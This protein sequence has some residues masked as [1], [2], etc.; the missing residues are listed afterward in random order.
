MAD[1][2]LL[3]QRVIV[4]LAHRNTNLAR[5]LERHRLHSTHARLA[6][7]LLDLADSNGQCLAAQVTHAA[8]A[9]LMCTTRE[10]E[11]RT[12]AQFVRLGLVAVGYRR[13]RVVDAE[14]LLRQSGCN[15]TAD[16]SDSAVRNLAVA[17]R[18]AAPDFTKGRRRQTSDNLRS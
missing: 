3:A 2:P 17:R 16:A 15:P 8:L 5:Q 4:L 9:K 18:A 6:E 1:H 11:T 13:L 7:T 12:L 10:T 14:G